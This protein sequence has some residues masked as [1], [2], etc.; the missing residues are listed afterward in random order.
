MK[1]LI[2]AGA[3]R[4]PI[5]DVRFLSNVST[6][7]TGAVLAGSFCEAGH[8]VSLLHGEGAVTPSTDLH[9]EAFSSA[10]D[11]KSRLQRHL[12]TGNYDAVIMTAAVADFRPAQPVAGKISSEQS[13]LTLRL[14][15]NDKILSQLKKF[16]PRPLTVV[17]FKL[18][19]AADE[20]ARRAA[21]SD[22]FAAGGVDLVVHNDLAE[23]R[24]VPRDRHP[25]WVYR[26]ATAT[27]VK[28]SGAASLA[29]EIEL[30]VKSTIDSGPGVSE[31]AF[32]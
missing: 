23:L 3:T 22:Q 8:A 15:R 6:G 29:A 32:A 7:R 16:S 28:V 11:L 13:E 25:F 1:L 30:R 5:D 4:E 26:S 10:E 31:S 27:P 12:T 24:T 18:T 14:V 9:C 17:G 21:V 2:T 19:V 20:S